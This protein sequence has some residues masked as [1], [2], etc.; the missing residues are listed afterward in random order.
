MVAS[1]SPPPPISVFKSHQS[2]LGAQRR[3]HEP[4]NEAAALWD[5]GSVQRQ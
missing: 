1:F 3:H 4:K 2:R 5:A